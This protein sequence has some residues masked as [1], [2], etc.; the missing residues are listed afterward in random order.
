MCSGRWKPGDGPVRLVLLPLA[1]SAFGMMAEVGSE[2]GLAQNGVAV[3]GAGMFAMLALTMAWMLWLSAG[4]PH[5]WNRRPSPRRSRDIDGKDLVRIGACASVMQGV[6][7][8]QEQRNDQPIN[9]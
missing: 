4:P 3:E 1:I 7:I 9:R 8:V 5:G 6:G 2:Q